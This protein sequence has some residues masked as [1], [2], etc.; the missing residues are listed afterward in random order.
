M[1]GFGPLSP[2]EIARAQAEDARV[3]AYW[4]PS[5]LASPA[6]TPASADPAAAYFGPPPPPPPAPPTDIVHAMPEPAPR[7]LSQP[8]DPATL[9]HQPNPGLPNYNP[10]YPAP[11]GE[12]PRA[13]SLIS[14]PAAKARVP[15]SPPATRDP[16]PV[17]REEAPATPVYG[18][19]VKRYGPD[20]FRPKP[21]GGSGGSKVDDYWGVKAEQ[22]KLVGTFDKDAQSKSREGAAEAD[23]MVNMA[24]RQADLARL[25]EEDAAIALAEQREA[26]QRFSD[27]MAE[28]EKQLEAVR[29]KKI[30]PQ[31]YLNNR[32]PVLTVL[33]SLF[34]GI[35]QGI[36]RLSNN[37]FIDD[38]NKEADRDIEAQRT[39][40]ANERESVSTRMNLLGQMRAQFKDHQLA[41]LQAKNLIYESAKDRIA[42][43]AARDESPVMQERTT[44]AVT[45]IERAQSQ[46]SLQIKEAAKREAEARAA[47]AAAQAR[48]ARKEQFDQTVKLIELGIEDKK[49]G[50]AVRKDQ[51]GQMQALGAELSKPE[52]V[53]ALKTI[54]DFKRQL[55]KFDAKGQPIINSATGEPELDLE[56][57]LPGVGHGAD[58]REGA[59]PPNMSPAWF[60]HPMLGVY[61]Y[62]AGELAGLSPVER[63]NR[64][65]WDR[66]A[67]AYQ[68]AVTGAGAGENEQ[69][70]IA[71][72]FGG[73]RT[74]AEQAAAIRMA[75]DVIRTRTSRVKAGFDPNVVRE[76]EQRE[77]EERLALP[78]PAPRKPVGEVTGSDERM[79]TNVHAVTEDDYWR[80]PKP[81]RNAS[82]RDDVP[83]YWRR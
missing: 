71:Q 75:D 58:L 79:K 44:Q 73:A 64:M 69:A 62:A 15:P 12:P 77:A 24:D 3:R 59:L 32:S 72:A 8:I 83:E 65:K 50:N 55:V 18:P 1:S 80:S 43:E 60:A 74:P 21:S 49:A 37:P 76:Y 47:A 4:N 13:W 40:L 78:Q 82:S 33:G 27:H 45:A 48:A 5:T 68:H 20:D 61:R 29:A 9:P 53:E 67:L 39:D 63:Q 7:E 16:A 34:G 54:G 28:T 70:K 51:Q 35:Y 11:P 31:R 22:K 2:E 41:E 56:R 38:L 36:N 26:E 14:G 57:G 66:L 25:K 30:D 17:S 81:K 23:R 10:N 46:L 42:A 6:S 52:F 19:P